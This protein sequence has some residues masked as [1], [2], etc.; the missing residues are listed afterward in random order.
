M[1]FTIRELLGEKFHADD[2]KPMVKSQDTSNCIPTPKQLEVTKLQV[3]QRRVLS[4][5][6]ANFRR[7]E[8]SIALAENLNSLYEST[9]VQ[10]VHTCG[11]AAHA[12]EVDAEMWDVYCDW[13]ANNGISIPVGQHITLDEV[14]KAIRQG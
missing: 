12:S 7:K 2:H 9:V 4:L 6:W 3:L 8:P 14:S 1:F 13:C 10:L 11:N 5:R